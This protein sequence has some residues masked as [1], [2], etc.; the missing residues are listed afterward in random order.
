[1][2]LQHLANLAM[3]NSSA[4]DDCHTIA[5]AELMTLENNIQKVLKKKQIK[6][7]DYSRAHLSETAARIDKVLHASL[8]LRGP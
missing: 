2:L 6:L 1:M 4:P 8:E 5:Y 3:G 7:D